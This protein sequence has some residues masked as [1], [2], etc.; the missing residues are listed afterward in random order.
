MDLLYPE[1]RYIEDQVPLHIYIPRKEIMFKLMRACIDVEK[2]EDLWI[3]AKTPQTK[4]SK[5]RDK[6]SKS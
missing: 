1:N 5:K 3:Y 4:V 6:K 2:P